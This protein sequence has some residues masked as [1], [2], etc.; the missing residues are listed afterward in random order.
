MVNSTRKHRS[1]KADRPRKPYKDFPLTPHASGKW[2]KKILGSTYY[3][4][5]WAKRVN[6]KL[7]RIDGDGWQEALEMYKAVADDRHAG[8]TP[9]AK[10]EQLTLADL[11]NHFL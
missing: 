7:E 10:S 5:R 2:Q 4:G 6:G 3:F 8:R 11:C 9:R 1:R